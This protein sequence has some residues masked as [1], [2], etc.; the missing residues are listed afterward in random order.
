MDKIKPFAWANKCARDG[1]LYGI[2]D[3]PD[4]EDTHAYAVEVGD[5]AVPLYD[6]SAIDALRAEVERL[7]QCLVA[8]HAESVERWKL[9][10][11]ASA[12]AKRYRWL[13]EGGFFQEVITARIGASGVTG[14]D[15]DEIVDSAMDNA[16]H[17]AANQ[18]LPMRRGP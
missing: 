2:E 18:G 9:L 13:S 15:F 5:E 16:M 10:L 3:G 6:Q 7:E 17:L 14:S 12:D 11:S 8:C 4:G 1:F